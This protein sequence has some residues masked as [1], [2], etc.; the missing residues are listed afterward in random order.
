[1]YLEGS[2]GRV[3]E[4]P[5]HSVGFGRKRLTIIGGTYFR[6]MPLPAIRRLLHAVEKRGHVPMVYLHPYDLDPHAEPLAYPAGYFAQRQGDRMRRAGRATAAE[7][8][9]ALARDYAF[10]AIGDSAEAAGGTPG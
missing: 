10:Q 3:E 8:L 7:K 6:L 9:S 5:L 1:M 4:K 2:E